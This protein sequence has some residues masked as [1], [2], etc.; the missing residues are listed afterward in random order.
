M[1]NRIKSRSSNRRKW[2]LPLV[3]ILIIAGLASGIYYKQRTQNQT[4]SVESPNTSTGTTIN[5]DPPTA[6]DKQAVDQHKDE[7]SKQQTPTDSTGKKVVTPVIVDAGQYEQQIEVRSFVPEIYESTGS[8]TI[9][10]TKDGSK[11]VKQVAATPDATTTRC[12]NLTVA[13]SEFSAGTWTIVVSYS[14]PT[15]QGSSQTKTFEVK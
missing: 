3:V 2:L 4:T 6:Q 12:S 9:I 7:L 5:L 15:A 13:R 14:S 1:K 10:F 11:I 8:C